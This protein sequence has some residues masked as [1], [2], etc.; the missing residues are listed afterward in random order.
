M[1]Y[2]IT[3][4]AGFIGCNA[5]NYLL[6]RGNQVVILDNLSR[7]G[8]EKN[9]AW[10]Q[11]KYGELPHARVD[12]RDFEGLKKTF[13]ENQDLD[14]VLHLAAQVAVTTSV[15]NPREDFEI[16]ALGT[17]NVLETIRTLDL[18]P[19]VIYSSTN[20]VYGE[21]QE[22]KTIRDG[23]RYI[24]SDLPK[25][26]SEAMPLDFHSP[27]GCSKGTA[28]QYVRDYHRIYGLRSVV[29]R[30]SCIYGT[31]Q[32]GVEDQGW[33]AWFIIAAI[34]GRPITIYGDGCQVRD[35]LYVDDLVCAYEQAVKNID[36]AQG[37][38]YNIGGGCTNTLAIWS[39]FGPLLHRLLKKDIPVS[40]A[41]WRPGDQP[42]F[43]SDIAKAQQELGWS[44]KI[45]VEEGIEKLFRW[46]DENRNLFE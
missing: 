8:S 13:T 10:L 21:M 44:P 36:I 42:I 40:Y 25:G 2:L 33:V 27:Y 1:K 7:A 31:R 5:A 32:F 28:D 29:L 15:A 39:E 43:I 4:G 35:V 18:N 30:Q 45:S 6:E 23:G 16:N 46:V 19:I 26:I 38:V 9:L 20:K 24:Y 3:G 17:F 14:V 41:D 12:I 37:Q 22:L 34:L 11:E